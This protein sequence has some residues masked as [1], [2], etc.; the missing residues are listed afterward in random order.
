MR[1]DPIGVFDSGVGGLNVLYM[2]ERLMPNESFIYLADKANLP[3]GNKTSDEIRAAAY[4]CADTLFS[5]NCKAVVIACNTATAQAVDDIRRLFSTRITVGLE[6]AVKPCYNELGKNGYAVALVTEATYFSPKFNRL[7]AAC[8]GKIKAAAR[9]E[10]AELIE[11]NMA[12]IGK[13]KPHVFSIL[14]EFGDAE[15]IILGCSHYT[16]IHD[17]IKEFYGGRIKI[18]DGAIGAAKRLQYCLSVSDMTAR[19]ATKTKTRFYSTQKMPREKN[20]CI[21]RF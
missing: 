5:M 8:D 12:A 4:F 2:C 13:I 11:K 16:Y 10:L 9:P 1:N 6:P 14:E 7:I 20:V 3:Y 21:A 18:Y 15:S 17:I 19:G